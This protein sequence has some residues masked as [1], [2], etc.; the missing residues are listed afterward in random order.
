MQNVHLYICLWASSRICLIALSTEGEGLGHDKV[1]LGVHVEEW[2]VEIG[3]GVLSRNHLSWIEWVRFHAWEMHNLLIRWKSGVIG[4][5]ASGKKAV[6]ALQGGVHRD[7]GVGCVRGVTESGVI[8]PE[9][10]SPQVSRH[11]PE[12]PDARRGTWCKTSIAPNSPAAIMADMS[13]GPH[14]STVLATHIDSAAY[15]M[16]QAPQN[17]RMACLVCIK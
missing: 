2:L 8:P 5:A 6:G 10:Q 14:P 9:D 15:P 17:S 4:P 16:S 13:Y 1:G 3:I 12:G 11:I 7:V